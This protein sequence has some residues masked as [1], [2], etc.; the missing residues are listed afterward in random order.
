[1]I[2]ASMLKQGLTALIFAAS[3]P[4]ALAAPAS[5]HS[6]QQQG[7]VTFLTGGIGQGQS[8]AIKDVMHQYPL[9]LEFAGKARGG[10]EYLSD[11]PVQVS[12]M[13]GHTVLKTTTKGP[14]LLAS[15]PDGRYSVMARYNGKDERRDVDITSSGHVHEFFLWQM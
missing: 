4:F 10:N 14:F 12:D 6:V 3:T 2:R 11:I 9:A 7:D 5:L 15:L 1:M 8:T 13:H